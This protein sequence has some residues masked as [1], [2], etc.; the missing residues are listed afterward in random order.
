MTHQ[1]GTHESPQASALWI[2]RRRQLCRRVQAIPPCFPL[3]KSHFLVAE[4]RLATPRPSAPH[5]GSRC[6]GC[7]CFNL[8]RLRGMAGDAAGTV[9]SSGH[10]C[11][12]DTAFVMLQSTQPAR[13]PPP[14]PLSPSHQKQPLPGSRP[15][16]SKPL[17]PA[18]EP[19]EVT[20]ASQTTKASPRRTDV[21]K[22]Q[23]HPCSVP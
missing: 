14:L 13:A 18:P 12:A 7:V 5:L 22:T 16:S 8:S 6:A 20:S 21:T 17:V 11:L 23:L 3:Q 4:P 2:Q 19:G 15:S 9:A 10:S 1:A